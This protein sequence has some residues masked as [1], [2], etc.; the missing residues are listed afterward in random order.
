MPA[1]VILGHAEFSATCR[2]WRFPP[3]CYTSESTERE[4]SSQCGLDA[5]QNS[6]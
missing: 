5:A 1:T 3:T 4:E 2:S 6:R